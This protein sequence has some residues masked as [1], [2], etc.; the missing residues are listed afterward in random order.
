MKVNKESILK[1]QI[2]HNSIATILYLFTSLLFTIPSILYLAKYKTVYHF[3]H[4]FTYTFTKAESIY[5]NYIN[6][7]IYLGLFFLLFFL[8]FTILK[9][10]NKIFKA[11]KNLFCFIVIIG[12]LFSII[13]PT[14]SLDVYSYIGNGWVDSNYHENP[15]YTS[16]QDVV[17]KNGPDEMLGKVARCWRDEPVVYGP[18]WSLICKGLTCFSFGNITLALYI[19]KIASF[20]IFLG[21]AILIDKITNKKFFVALFALN[22]FILFEFLSNVH[23]DIFL[24]FFILLAIYF[25]KKKKNISL[26][27]ASIAVATG[28]KYLS[29]L[30]LP[31]LLVY[32]L[33]EDSLKTKIKK[34]CFYGI[35][36][37]VL[38]FLF[39][40]VYIKDFQ[41]L[42]GIFVQ[43]NKY[44][45]S[46]FLALYYFLNGD[47][48]ALNLIK[49]L[50]LSIF[51]ISYIAIILKLFFS[52]TSKDITFRKT[53]RTYQI[54]LLVF[55]FVLI[56]NFNPW[57]VIWLFP[58]L[59]W[60]KAKNIRLT[61]YL[62]LGA[63]VSYSITYATRVDD[64][65]VGI[66]YLV[67]MLLT[68]G[69]L[70]VYREIHKKMIQKRN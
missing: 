3:I 42:S 52:K 28:I 24:V 53:L 20:I 49:I 61:L 36:F 47:Q 40:L 4:V 46:I 57:Y 29:I 33:K 30:L 60:Q 48:K 43:Q 6:T 12:I 32:V 14:T 34:V 1:K 68:V 63:L 19:F 16:V 65:T 66:P 9:N 56:T 25:I 21:S 41:V 7:I 51:A 55:T 27:V 23:N 44:G 58:T 64:E 62:S 11:K 17:N 38:L 22:P 2:N 45:R 15:Y 50:A 26:A 69:I 10:I 70:Y 35:E 8:Y 13:I 31:F 37:I 67:L 39:Y 59:L 18:V 54:F 5:D